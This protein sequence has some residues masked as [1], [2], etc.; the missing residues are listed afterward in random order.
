MSHVIH[1]VVIV[2]AHGYVRNGLMSDIPVPDVDGFRDS[3]PPEWRHLVIGPVRPVINDFD[4]WM[5]L[6]DG[7]KEGWEESDLGNEL[8]ARF[9]ALFSWTYEDGSSPFEVVHVRF[10]K[11]ESGREMATAT[12]PR[13]RRRKS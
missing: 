3:L 7:S 10:G 8:R 4:T 12:R 9:T 5:F 6:P 13:T 1:D 2:V 11:H